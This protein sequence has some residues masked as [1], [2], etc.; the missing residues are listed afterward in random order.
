MLLERLLQRAAAGDKAGGCGALGLAST[1][2]VV[3]AAE[4]RE[5]GAV[6]LALAGAGGADV[7]EQLLE[8]GV[9]AGALGAR[10][11]EPAIE[12]PLQL[13]LPGKEVILP[14]L[15]GDAGVLL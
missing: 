14:A 8:V 2:L 10:V 4:I 11:G 13:A 7:A 1:E 6:V 3:P 9:M 12:R 5:R 15:V